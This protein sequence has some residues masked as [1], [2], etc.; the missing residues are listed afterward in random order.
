M[1]VVT[2]HRLGEDA[3]KE[4]G[5]FGSHKWLI[6]RRVSQ[7]FFLSLFFVGPLTGFWLVKGNLAGSLTLDFLPLTDPLMLVQSF[8]AGHSIATDALIGAAIVI[9]AY[10]LLGG[11]TYCS[12][13]CPINVV[14]DASNWLRQRMGLKGGVQLSRKARYWVL[15]MCVVA[16]AATGAIVWEM[17]NPITILQRGLIF[18]VGFA[19]AVV[20]AVF[21]F[22]LFVSRRGWCS[23]LCPVGAFYSLIGLLSLTRVSAVRRSACNNCM[24]CYAVCPEPQVISPALKGEEKE[25]GPIILSS[26]CTNC[27]RCI[28]VCAPDVFEFTNRFNGE[29]EPSAPALKEAA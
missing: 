21:L 15:A 18:G 27:G 24:D 1:T 13:V 16:S 23:H 12:W 28:D 19:W 6:L 8:F 4:K 7:I 5:W 22:D 25:V 2:N 10:A 17:V 14:T 20:L 3:L 26:D 9:V 11:R 29:V